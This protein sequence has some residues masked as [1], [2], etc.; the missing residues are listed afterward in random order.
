MFRIL[1]LV[2]SLSAGGAAAWLALSMQAPAAVPAAAVFNEPVRQQA[3][4][5][6]VAAADL[7]QGETLSGDNALAG[8]AGT[9]RTYRL[10]PAV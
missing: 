6:L 10:H 4:E 5:V 1:I 2:V 8:M 7:P 9:L 3:E